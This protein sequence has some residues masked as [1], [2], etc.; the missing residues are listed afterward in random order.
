M[1]AV[2]GMSEP[3]DPRQD[4]EPKLVIEQGEVGLGLGPSGPAEAGASGIDTASYQ[5]GQVE[6]TVKGGGPPFGAT[7]FLLSQLQ[8]SLPP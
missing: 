5:Q 8:F 3:T 7:S 6:D 1:L 4:I 2:L